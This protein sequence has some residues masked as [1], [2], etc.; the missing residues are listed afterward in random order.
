MIRKSV[1]ALI[2]GRH[3]ALLSLWL[4]AGVCTAQPAV[5]VGLATITSTEI[6]R[7]LSLTGTVTA[8][9][10]ARLSVATAGLVADLV[11]DTGATVAQGAPLLRLDAELAQLR[12]AAAEAQMAQARVRLQEAERRQQE[13]QALLPQR[14]IAE[15]TVRELVSN[16]DAA[17]AELQQAVA[18]SSLAAAVLARHTLYAPFAGVISLRRTERG[19]WLNPGQPV[20]DLVGL[21]DLRLDFAVPEDY[22]TF[23]A[24]GAPITFISAADPAADKV[25]T[26]AS[27]VPVADAAARTFLLRVEPAAAA[28]P[29]LLPGMSVTARL[30]LA[31]GRSGVA[32]PR[33]ALVRYP[34]GRIVVWTA[35]REGEALVARENTVSTGLTFAGRIEITQGLPD[36]ARVV[37]RGNEALQPGLVLLP[38]SDSL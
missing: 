2:A 28:R 30:A 1:G 9:H 8:T 21:D 11:V 19:E 20:F 16:R 12:Q 37:V 7:E 15:T 3:A 18:E 10:N 13:A 29:G 17:R 14:G 38:T 26:V 32:V 25:G 34:D 24:P 35:E 6:L 27:L 4:V 23:L 31:T 36:G 33:D 22:L 5:P